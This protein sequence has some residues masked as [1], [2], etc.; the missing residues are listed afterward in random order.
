MLNEHLLQ[1]GR[2]VVLHCGVSMSPIFLILLDGR[3]LNGSGVM[4]GDYVDW[5]SLST[6]NVKEI[7]VIRGPK[8]AEFGN[9]FGGVINVVTKNRNQLPGKTSVEASYGVFSPEHA[10]DVHENGKTDGSI[11]HHANIGHAASLDLYASHGK[12]KPFL[13]NNYY[14]VTNFGGNI[15][16]YLPLDITL[17]AA[18]RNSIQYRG[19]A[20]GN[21]L[22]DAYYNSDY[23]QSNESAGGGPGVAWKGGD[24]YFGD[25]SYWKNIRNQTDYGFVENTVRGHTGRMFWSINKKDG[26]NR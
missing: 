21:H 2:V 15:S 14:D 23:P 18:L 26:G 17:G 4:G 8:S 10:D 9:T 19:F 3:P 24:F 5:S 7:E 13:R 1:P 25:R 12:G 6:D 20:I 22:T 11:F 16:L